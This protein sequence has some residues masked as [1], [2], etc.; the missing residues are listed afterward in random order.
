MY[1]SRLSSNNF[2]GRL[3]DFFQSWTKLQ[4][5]EI[6]GRGFEG[7]IPSSISLLN[8]LQELRITDLNG[9][10]SEFPPFENL[11][12]L[13]TLDLSFN[14]LT[15]AVPDSSYICTHCENS[16]YSLHINCGGEEARIGKTTF[17]QDNESDG[18]AK[19]VPKKAEWGYSSSG[20]FWNRRLPTDL[21]IAE[22][23]STLLMNDTELYKDA[24]LAATSLTYYGR[25]LAKGNYTVTLY[26]SEIVFADNN[27][28]V[29]LGRRFFD[30]YIQEK[31]IAKDFNIEKEANGTSKAL[32]KSFPHVAV[33]NYVEIRFYYAGKGSW[34]IPGKLLDGTDIAVKQLSSRSSQGNREFVN[35]IGLISTLCHPNLVRLYGCSVDNSQLFLVYEYL[36]NN[37]LGH[38]LFEEGGHLR[39][40]WPTRKKICVGIARGLAFLHDE[41]AIKIVHRDIKATNVLLDHDLNPKISDFGLAKLNEE[42]NTHISTRIAGTIGYMAPEYAMRGYLTEK[43]DVYSFGVVALEIVAGRSN[44]KFEPSGDLFCLLDLA[45]ILQQ[46]GKL[47]ELVDPR[48]GRDYNEDEALTIIQVALLCINPSP[49]L[50]PTMSKALSMLEGNIEVEELIL[51]PSSLSFSGFTAAVI[52]LA[53]FVGFGVCTDCSSTLPEEV[54]SLHQIAREVQKKDSDCST[55]PC[56]QSASNTCWKSKDDPTKKYTN[57]VNCTCLNSTWHITDIYWKGQNL[58]DVLPKSL[59]KLRYIKTMK[60]LTC[61]PYFVLISDL[62]RNVLTGTVPVEWIDTKLKFVSL[63]A[64]RLS[65]PIP[66]YLGKITTL[67]QLSIESNQFDGTV[68]AELG[69]LVSLTNLTLSDNKLTGHLP[70]ELKNLRNLTKLLLSSNNFNGSLPDF[71]KHYSELQ[72]LE[73]IGSGFEGP[74][75][76][77]ISSLHKLQ[78]LYLTGNMLNGPIPNWIA[79]ADDTS[80]IDI[81]YNNFTDNPEE[82]LCSRHTIDSSACLKRLRCPKERYTLHINCGG[83]ETRIGKITYLQD[84]EKSGAATF[85]HEKPDWGFSSSGEFW[86]ADTN[87]YIWQSTSK[88]IGKSDE[89]LY[90][91]A[92]LSATSLTYCGRCLANGNYSVTLHFSEIIFTDGDTYMS[93]GRR[94][95]DIYIQ[96]KL[97]FKDFDIVKEANGTHKAF[98]KVFSNISVTNS[99]IEIRF[100]YAGKGSTQIP[101]KGHYGPLISAISVESQFNP[102][103]DW[104][105]VM[106]ALVAA[107][108]FL[109]GIALVAFWWKR[110]K[111]IIKSREQELRVLNPQIGLFTYKQIKAACN[112]FNTA[113]KLGEGGFGSVYKGTLL[114][115]THIAVKQLSA[116]SSQGN[117]EFVNEIGMISSMCHPNLVRLYGCCVDTS[118]LFL[119]YEYLVNKDLGHALFGPD[120]GRL[121]LDWPIRICIGIAKGL[122]FLHEESRIK[123]VHRDIKATNVLLDRNLNPKISDF[124]LARLNEEEVTHIS[125]RIAGTIGYMAPEYALWGYLTPKADVFSFGVVVLEVVAGRSNMKFE[126]SEDHFCLL[127]WVIHGSRILWLYIH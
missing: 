72:F 17:E 118:Q 90:K 69:N 12:E 19:F 106:W 31:L 73:M 49:A 81:S 41:S 51:E 58:A 104:K 28:F 15:G 71:I 5:L 89:G 93:I 68:P 42:D 32:I 22:N 86:K 123:I 40:D 23:K 112:N 56:S 33:T 107:T 117:R 21:Y 35:E 36:E 84:H 67:T 44:M 121:K 88:I 103:F 115:G 14:K 126:P 4:A 76:S 101:V 61:P 82:P 122:A 9:D 7:P 100:Y 54:E 63:F 34:Q 37:D 95:F 113:N 43:A 119:V 99:T 127:D 110:R 108:S 66:K 27:S 50:R 125:T 30:I 13:N 57:L 59:S 87:H 62:A 98:K 70:L 24:R 47:I 6:Q 83:P 8:N 109:I 39:F 46:N 25:C 74:I 77:N 75:P 60:P 10:G 80:Q 29:S 105:I 102:P 2:R 52:L 114:N 64:N 116:K 26:F 16:R 120:D 1:C 79:S 38:A 20:E 111:E 94:V 48:L 65:G 85:F 97:Y 53:F 3:P 92:R 124:G 96:E 45:F 18:A 78:E 91:D 11:N 55:D